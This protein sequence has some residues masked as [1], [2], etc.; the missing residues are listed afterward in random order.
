VIKMQFARNY[1]KGK[2]TKLNHG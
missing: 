1:A 2:G